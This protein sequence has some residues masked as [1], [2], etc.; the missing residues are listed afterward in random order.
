MLGC[1]LPEVE[2]GGRAVERER[3]SVDIDEGPRQRRRGNKRRRGTGG[4]E[5]E[6]KSGGNEGR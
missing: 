5:T 3:Y 2:R 4:R 1:L 6:K